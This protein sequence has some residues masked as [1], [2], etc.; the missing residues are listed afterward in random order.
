[1]IAKSDFKIVH[2]NLNN[3]NILI[4]PMEYADYDNVYQLWSTIHGFRIRSIDD[5]RDGIYRFLNRNPSTSIVAVNKN[6]QIVGAILCGH[7]GRT[8]CLYHVCVREDYRKKGIG[9]AMT[10]SCIEALKREHI[11]KISL[12]AF[13]ENEVGNKFWKDEKWSKREEIN[14]YDLSLN[15]ENI[16]KYIE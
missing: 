4:R 14:Y 1:M 15:D 10:N 8:G 5:S 9:D 13:K 16:S 7:D 3:E 6:K 2:I 12:I 11:N